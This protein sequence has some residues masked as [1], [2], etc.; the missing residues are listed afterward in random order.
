MMTTAGFER[1]RVTTVYCLLTTD[2]CLLSTQSYAPGRSRHYAGDL[3]RQPR[4]GLEHGAAAPLDARRAESR[5]APRRR[6]RH[7]PRLRHRL[8]PPRDGEDSREPPLP[9][10]RALLGQ[11]RLHRRGL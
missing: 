10:D 7:R 6:D 8:P 3:T 5:P 1:R 9:Y 4:D 2:Y 11:A